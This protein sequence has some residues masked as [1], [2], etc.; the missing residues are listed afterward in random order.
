MKQLKDAN[1]QPN[2][3]F[4]TNTGSYCD[5]LTH[6]QPPSKD[7]KQQAKPFTRGK[8][9]NLVEP[10]QAAMQIKLLSHTGSNDNAQPHYKKFKGR[11]ELRKSHIDTTFKA[12]LSKTL[13][14][15]DGA[16]AVEPQ[17][18]RAGVLQRRQQEVKRLLPATLAA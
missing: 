4:R 6:D 8:F 7:I 5:S 2:H 13:F 17:R 11:H 18:Q 1:H 3:F 10:L 15:P 14:P 9:K 16:A 12:H